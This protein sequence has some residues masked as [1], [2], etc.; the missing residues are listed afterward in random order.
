MNKKEFIKA[1]SGKTGFTQ[2]DVDAVI[3]AMIEVIGEAVKAHK[4]V[5]VV[6][7]GKFV[8][9]V[10]PARERRNPQTG[11]VVMCEEKNTIKFRPSSVLKEAIN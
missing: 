3:S 11:A 7:F 4:D 9:K 1:I 2:K 5:N 6:G 10:S 8:S